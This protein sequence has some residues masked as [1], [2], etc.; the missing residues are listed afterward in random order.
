MNPEN[1]RGNSDIDDLRE[2][3]AHFLD[4]KLSGRAGQIGECLGCFVARLITLH[5][6]EPSIQH[7]KKPSQHF[8]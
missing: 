5:S 6:G 8:G 7:A 4:G 2:D 3:K 1:L